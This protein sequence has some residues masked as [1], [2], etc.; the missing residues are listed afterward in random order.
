MEINIQSVKNYIFWQAYKD[1]PSL[2][3]GGLY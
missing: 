1:L 2:Q 3:I